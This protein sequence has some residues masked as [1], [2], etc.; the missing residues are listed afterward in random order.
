MKVVNPAYRYPSLATPIEKLIYEGHGGMKS[1]NTQDGG[2][3]I[4]DN[5]NKPPISLNIENRQMDNTIFFPKNANTNAI[6]N[7]IA[8][9][10]T[11]QTGAGKNGL[12]LM[13][14]W[15][16]QIKKFNKKKNTTT[17]YSDRIKG[18]GKQ[19]RT[20]QTK[21]KRKTKRKN[22]KRRTNRKTKRKKKTKETKRRRNKYIESKKLKTKL[23]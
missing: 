17:L 15:I 1:T 10:N 23:N 6:T 22:N 19:A 20:F 11:I 13:Q 9:D 12:S 18:C 4:G 5:H 14:K 3:I 8:T 21:Q 16:A 7:S 2:N